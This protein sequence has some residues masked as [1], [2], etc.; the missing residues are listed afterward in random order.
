[1]YIRGPESLRVICMLNTFNLNKCPSLLATIHFMTPAAG[2]LF[3]LLH[4]NPTIHISPLAC[5]AIYP[6]SFFG[7]SFGDIGHQYVCLLS[8]IM[9]LAKIHLKNSTAISF[10]KNHDPVTQDNPQ[11]LL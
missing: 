4:I 11:T 2:A 8:I 5:S 9:G 1:M 3:M 6:L 10:F 7:V